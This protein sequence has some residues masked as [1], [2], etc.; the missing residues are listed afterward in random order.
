MVIDYNIEKSTPNLEKRITKN[1]Q[2]IKH[3]NLRHTNNQEIGQWDE[4]T[5]TFIHN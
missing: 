5:L 1:L 3:Q 2:I 4:N